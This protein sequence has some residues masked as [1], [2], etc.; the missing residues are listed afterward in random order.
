MIASENALESRL[1]NLERRARRDRR[2]ASTALIALVALATLSWQERA[3]PAEFDELR[4]KRIDIV[5]E[6]GR[7][8]LVLSCEER[9][10][11]PVLN[12]K[13]W[14]RSIAP[15]GLIFYKS[16]GDE[17]GGLVLAKAGATNA[18][19]MILDYSNSEAI[20]IGV[21]ETKGGSYGA[22][23]KITDRLPL[24]ADVN[25]V[26][27]VGPERVRVSSEDG[28]AQISLSDERGRPRI[29]MVVEPGGKG[30]IELLDEAGEVVAL[31]P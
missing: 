11:L 21:Q 28:R 24:D 5:D 29:R 4:A 3:K 1:R 6:Q 22:R 20:Q 15:A 14:P 27:T 23:L 25:K 2:L 26:G 18:N 16:D 31:W 10:P 13:E 30:G 8:R 7:R 12:G 9:F 19:L 17:C